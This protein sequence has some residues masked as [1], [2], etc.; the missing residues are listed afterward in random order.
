MPRIVML[1]DNSTN[2]ARG[3]GEPLLYVPES[4]A[5]I[6]PSGP[7][8]VEYHWGDS[9]DSGTP[10]G[11]DSE[12][13]YDS[14]ELRSSHHLCVACKHTFNYFCKYN[15]VSG[16]E[17]ISMKN[18]VLHSESILSLFMFANLANCF[19]CRKI[20]SKI[21]TMYP[22]LDPNSPSSYKVECCWTIDGGLSRET[23]MWMVIYDSSVPRKPS[24]NYQHVLRIGLWPKAHYGIHFGKDTDQKTLLGSRGVRGGGDDF[25]NEDTTESAKTR[26]LAQSWFARCTHN[27]NGQHGICNRKEGTYLPTRLLDVRSALERGQALLVCPDLTPEAFGTN[28]RYATVSHCWGAAGANEHIVLLTQNVD[29]RRVDGTAWDILPKTFQDA[30]KIASWLGLD[31]LWIDCMCIMQNSASD[32]QKE[33]SAMDRVYMNAEVNISADWG[34][35]SQAGCFSKRNKIDTIPLEFASPKS[36]RAWIVTTE[37]AFFWMSSAPSLSRAWIHRERQLARRILH[38]TKKEL[39]WECCGQGKACFASETMPG[40]SPF[41]NVFKGEIKFQIQFAN[42]AV[43]TPGLQHPSA[44]DR[45]DKIHQLWNSTCQDLSNKSVTYASDLPVI[46]SSLAK[47]FQALMPDDEYVAGLW[48]STLVEALTWFVPGDK[49]E[50]DG[51]IAPSWS[52]LSAASPVKLYYPGHVQRKRIVAEIVAIDTK[53]DPSSDNPYG[54]LVSGSSLRVRGFLRRLHFHFVGPPNHG[55]ILS[56]VEKDSDGRDRL[57]VIGPDWDKHEGLVFRLTTDSMVT[58]PYQE[59]EC[60]ALF[61]TLNEW[62]QFLC[63]CRRR[64][65]CILLEMVTG[66]SGHGHVDENVYRRIGTLED[67]S[68][69]YSFKMR[70]RVAE[71]STVRE[72][73]SSRDMFEE[74]PTAFAGKP[75]PET[76]FHG[77]EDVGAAEAEETDVAGDEVEASASGRRD[78]ASSTDTDYADGEIWTC[79]VQYIQRKRWSIIREFK[80]QQDEGKETQEG[81]SNLEQLGTC[82]QGNRGR[83]I[84]GESQG[85]NYGSLNDSFGNKVCDDQDGGREETEG[86]HKGNEHSDQGDDEDEDGEEEADNNKEEE[87]S[88]SRGDSSEEEDRHREDLHLSV[89]IVQI[90]DNPSSGLAPMTTAVDTRDAW[91]RLQEAKTFISE[92]MAHGKNQPQDPAAA[93]YQFDDV[94]HQWQELRG[95][96]PWLERLETIEITLV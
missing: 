15:E 55:I 61:T 11:D 19:I 23:K 27:T 41:E 4:P 56:V 51:Y 72:A 6:L 81:S 26:S 87:D 95:V 44:E 37:D 33:A 25:V 8:P 73:G 74:N 50:Y 5:T 29:T 85:E 40:G 78:S 9:E 32:W 13:A 75:Q 69:T 34:R 91:K 93:L 84:D 39:V 49:P 30:F 16:D 82:G 86:K 10:H 14:M 3:W 90:H 18:N 62:A 76:W 64:L 1:H 48:R 42:L 20:W 94:L 52:W 60:F 89:V 77:Q 28:P 17:R 58:L 36:E 96:V 46:L 92:T 57:R 83:G 24:Y 47:E 71:N 66:N 12:D 7:L 22:N 68:D 35:D 54:Q 88:D 80:E 67:I 63:N 2:Q 79:L 38:F 31:W 45:L 21:K 59:W 65:S 70:Y 43:F 53:V